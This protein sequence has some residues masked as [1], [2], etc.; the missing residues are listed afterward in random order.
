[1]VLM[2]AASAA[3]MLLTSIL[4]AKE[5]LAS[6]SVNS[7]VASTLLSVLTSLE[8]LIVDLPGETRDRNAPVM[9]EL[10]ST[11][12]EIIKGTAATIK[13]DGSRSKFSRLCSFLFARAT[14]LK[15]LALVQRLNLLVSTLHLSSSLQEQKRKS[16]QDTL[17]AVNMS[18]LNSQSLNDDLLMRKDIKVEVEHLAKL[19]Q[20]RSAHEG[21]LSPLSSPTSSRDSSGYMSKE[22]LQSVFVTQ[23]FSKAKNV[24]QQASSVESE[25]KALEDLTSVVAFLEEQESADIPEEDLHFGQL[26]GK[27]GFGYVIKAE[28]AGT[29]V[30]VK[31]INSSLQG[32]LTMSS[33]LEFGAELNTWK[34][35]N[36]PNVV[37]L[38][39][40]SFNKEKQV[41]SFV[42]ELCEASLNTLLHESL[43]IEVDNKLVLDVS[44][45][46]MR[47]V[48]YLHS[49]SVIH[50]DIKPKNVLLNWVGN[51]WQAKL[52]DFGMTLA[53][54]ESVSKTMGGALG[55]TP[56]YMAPELLQVPSYLSFKSDIFSFGI[57]LWEILQRKHPYEG[58]SL[59]AVLA[60]ALT[61]QRPDFERNAKFHAWFYDLMQSCWH[62]DRALRPTASEVLK[63]LDDRIWPL[64]EEGE[65]T[66][67]VLPENSVQLTIADATTTS[68]PFATQPASQ[69]HT[70]RQK[71]GTPTGALSG[72]SKAITPLPELKPEQTK[73]GI[74]EPSKMSSEE[75]S[76]LWEKHKFLWIA[77]ILFVCAL[78]IL[79]IALGVALPASA[80]T[81]QRSNGTATSC[82]YPSGSDDA[83]FCSL[84][85]NWVCNGQGCNVDIGELSF[86]LVKFVDGVA[87]A[88]PNF[89]TCPDELSQNDAAASSFLQVLVELSFRQRVCPL[90][91]GSVGLAF[92]RHNVAEV[93]QDS[94]RGV[95]G[96]LESTSDVSAKAFQ[97]VKVDEVDGTTV[98]SMMVAATG[99]IVAAPVKPGLGKEV[100]VFD[101]GAV[102]Q[103]FESRFSFYKLEED[104]TR[105]RL[106]VVPLIRR[107]LLRREMEEEPLDRVVCMDPL[108]QDRLLVANAEFNRSSDCDVSVSPLN[109]DAEDALRIAF[110]PMPNPTASPTIQTA[111]PT[112]AI[113]ANPSVGVTGTPTSSPTKLPTN[114]P[115]LQPTLQT[116]EPTTNAPSSSPTTSRPTKSDETMAPTRFPTS[117]APSASPSVSPSRSPTSGPT[118][119]PTRQPTS[120]PTARPTSQPS[121][122]PTGQPT[123]STLA[124]SRSPTKFPTAFPT[125]TSPTKQPTAGTSSPTLTPTRQPTQ[126]PSR[127]PS[128]SPIR[129]TAAPTAVPT[130]IPTAIPTSGPTVG[131]AGP[132]QAP[133]TAIP[134]RSPTIA[135]TA[136]VTTSSPTIS[137]ASPSIATATPSIAT[138]S[139]S[140]AATLNP[141][142]FAPTT[143]PTGL[144]VSTSAPTEGATEG[145]TASPA[146][147][148]TAATPSPISVAAT[149]KPTITPTVELQLG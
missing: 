40:T 14:N 1:M 10:D 132:T 103:G 129:Q 25:T 43:D 32:T 68:A 17:A 58:V 47:G 138:S 120:L 52:C 19:E 44:T 21:N 48:K 77:L 143:S 22:G 39:G 80:P 141:T 51:A 16:I 7:R 42:M 139:P 140:A 8:Q 29:P 49:K 9:L 119:M 148:P 45:G 114:A 116:R 33:V 112:P 70:L 145:P 46:V 95:S 65:V 75:E 134:S 28:W 133:P 27:G 84:N 61:G 146:L 96:R 64:P 89:P 137:T 111:A 118:A 76:S 136:V 102:E 83:P 108:S 20:L 131:T 100:Q 18:D 82:A 36:H 85:A 107:S 144:S 37:R 147:L 41:I 126:V 90:P 60:A 121:L 87:Q 31:V 74:E 4:T 105:V 66:P 30:A 99:R 127:N 3:G 62:Q 125:T 6:A 113:T 38:L 81:L 101:Q 93:L 59:N 55:G 88:N 109:A 67:I 123:V 56:M 2:A 12:N 71:T 149:G 78:I 130:S 15:L 124:P 69:A 115:T 122:Q 11:V 13:R 5:M 104:P 50:R 98:Y 54:E 106:G 34:G 72:S 91:T 63:A 73:D 135:P 94:L 117:Q 35:L 53:K 57:L 86:P 79:G 142:T 128:Q 23:V 97:F 24:L 92:A 110:S 26:L